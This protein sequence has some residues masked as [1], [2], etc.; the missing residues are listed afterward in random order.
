L[1]VEICD[2]GANTTACH[3]TTTQ[4]DNIKRALQPFAVLLSTTYLY[5]TLTESNPLKQWSEEH[6]VCSG[7][8]NVDATTQTQR[9]TKRKQGI[10]RSG[11]FVFATILRSWGKCEP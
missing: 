6:F 9:R 4:K 1:A 8:R 5:D 2:N 7:D 3:F 10:A 11:L